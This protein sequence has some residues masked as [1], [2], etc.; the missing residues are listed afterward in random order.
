M[1]TGFVFCTSSSVRSLMTNQSRNRGDRYRGRSSTCGNVSEVE[2]SQNAVRTS[3]IR[4]VPSCGGSVRTRTGDL[5]LPLSYGA[6][7]RTCN[8]WLA[9]EALRIYRFYGLRRDR[10]GSRHR[11]GY[12]IGFSTE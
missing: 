10:R 3:S 12:G 1:G 6:S 5:R 7:P 9:G 4:Y 11:S 2:T 8:G